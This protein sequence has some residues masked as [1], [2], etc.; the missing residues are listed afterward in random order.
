MTRWLP[1]ADPWTFQN[2]TITRA[3]ATEQEDLFWALKGG[4][5][6]FGTVT[7]VELYTHEQTPGVYVG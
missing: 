1:D 5:N 3:S 2:G 6:R 7:S 4:L